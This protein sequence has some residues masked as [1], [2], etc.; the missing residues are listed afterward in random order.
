MFSFYKKI[1]LILK[2]VNWYQKLPFFAGSK[3]NKSFSSLSSTTNDPNNLLGRFLFGVA[4]STEASVDHEH[5]APHL[6]C[7]IFNVIFFTWNRHYCKHDSDCPTRE[8]CCTLIRDV[9]IFHYC[10]PP[11]RGSGFFVNAFGDH[12]YA[13]SDLDL[14]SM[15]SVPKKSKLK[16]VIQD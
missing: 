16:E 13:S 4:E 14:R 10:S 9:D 12:N 11:A 1:A 3:I 2:I 5:A 7:P 6:I 8:L 15:D